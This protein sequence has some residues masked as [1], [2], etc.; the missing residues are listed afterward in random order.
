VFVEGALPAHQRTELCVQ[1]EGCDRVN[2]LHLQELDGFY[3]VE[4]QAPAV[5]AASIDLLQ[6]RVEPPRGKELFA[7]LEVLGH[8]RDLGQ[9]SGDRRVR[10]K[11]RLDRRL[12]GCA[13]HQ[14]RRAHRFI[15]LE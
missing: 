8:E 2:E 7:R 5:H 14:G 12:R 1:Y 10:P 3:L 4:R 15:P 11:G 6:V 9:G 13:R